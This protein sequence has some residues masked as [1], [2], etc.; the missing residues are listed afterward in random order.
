MPDL[1][2]R[3]AAALA[4]RYTLERQIGTGGMA[5]VFLAE[6][7][8]HQRKVA[9]KVLRPELGATLGGDRFFREIQIAAQLQHPHILPL[10]DSG[11]ADGFL[12]YAMPYVEGESLRERLARGGEL[13]VQE[14]VRLLVEVVDA[15]A[16]AHG[17]GVVHRD[18]KPDNVLLSG[19]HAL[20]SDFG[21]AK[22]V[23]EATGRQQLTT[24]GV[25]LGT[26]A[27]M[28][29]EQASA[30][31]HVDHRADLYA[32]GVLGY[33]LLAGR[34]PFTGGSAQEVLA[35]HVTQAPTP[36][37]TL[38]PT[39]SPALATVI[40][41]CLE[42]RPADRWQS[43]DQ[44][45]AQL[46]P[47]ATPSGGH[48]A[49]GI[50]AVPRAQPAM[51]MRW[52]FLGGVAVGVI[53]LVLLASRLNRP[54]VPAM[55]IGR[56][57]Q[58]T[59][60]PGLEI[61]PSLSPDGRILAYAAGAL[62]PR[63]FVRQVDGGTP[64]PV[65][66][67]LPGPQIGPAW[68]PD[69]KLLLFRS[70]RGIELVPALGG[71]PRL[72]ASDPNPL[73]MFASAWSP[74][75]RQ[76]AFR[77]G[78]T[79]Y[80]ATVDGGS[81]RPLVAG[82]NVHSMAW[83]PDGKWIAYVYGNPA[84]VVPGTFFGNLAPSEIRVSSVAGD[85]P[86]RVTDDTTSNL[87]PAW[88]PDGT[89]L[90][91]SNRDGGKDLYAVRLGRDGQ[92]QGQPARLTT[93]LNA[94]AI[95]VSGD[96]SRIAY[97]LFTETSNVWSIQVPATGSV[98]ISAARQVTSGNQV[99]ESFDVSSDGRWLVFDSNRRGNS[100]LYR[101]PLD[102]PGEPEQLTSGPLDKFFP[103]FSPDGREILFH[104]FVQ[105]RRQIY[106]I[107]SAGG[108]QVS[109]APEPDDD[110]AGLWSTDGRSIFYTANLASISSVE[111][112]VVTR[113]AAGTWGNPKLWRR[114][115]FGPV[116]APDG[117]LVACS[118]RDLNTLVATLDGD[119]VRTVNSAPYTTGSVGTA[120]FV[121]SPDSRFLNFLKPT[122]DS[123]GVWVLPAT[124]GT[125]RRSVRFDDDARQ[126]HRFGFRLSGG[127]VYVTL[128]DLQSDIWVAEVER[129]R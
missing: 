82:V 124:G 99:I 109:V 2:A 15:L 125:A 42:K 104:S 20:L 11:E 41:R 18:I 122:G 56:R 55:Q 85:P 10:L 19:R 68:S 17:R 12:F 71:T 88:T 86:V 40:M 9:V 62:E 46:E 112:R 50:P 35:A 117:K 87:S 13:P 69:G 80:V 105:G 91:I 113:D 102:R 33:E 73:F 27:Y 1:L 98:S 23:S 92:P 22:A 28:A 83:S 49:A 76:V 116:P 89:L 106:V 53:G 108:A 114:G 70:Q 8:R 100:D 5:L 16:Y 31:P 129:K 96:G 60:D 52:L 103:R 67:D 34:P 101:I 95:A 36:L 63:I 21:V 75:G 24:A 119:S 43:A 57:I 77:R 120:T 37:G 81:V 127:R 111:A 64:I 78:E 97:S 38:R 25:A 6:D 84:S 7:L 51:P 54:G 107:L 110:R 90:F 123:A 61:Q 79:L 39:V 128:G 3:I 26:P 29:P 58:V 48:T 45:L 4:D 32:V 93:G 118:T 66:R 59:L 65:A 121:W 94:Q 30:D 115:C 72:L 14:A 44:L 126:W 74:D 47:L